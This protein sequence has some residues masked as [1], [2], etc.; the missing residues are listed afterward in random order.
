MARE[1]HERVLLGG[2]AEASHLRVVEVELGVVAAPEV[3]ATEPDAEVDQQPRPA[4]D[5][6]L[7]VRRRLRRCTSSSARP[8]SCARLAQ[9]GAEPGGRRQLLPNQPGDLVLRPDEPATLHARGAS[10]AWPGHEVGERAARSP[11]PLTVAHRSRS[12]ET[13]AG[14]PT[15]TRQRSGWLLD[16][17]PLRPGPRVAGVVEGST[18][19]RRRTVRSPSRSAGSHTTRSGVSHGSSPAAS[20][21]SKAW[22]ASASVAGVE[23][24]SSS[25]H[26]A[27]RAARARHPVVEHLALDRRST[28]RRA[29]RRVHP[30][31]SA[32]PGGSWRKMIIAILFQCK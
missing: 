18:T 9:A 20:R 4:R 8:S 17:P 11:S 27:R 26:L 29:R 5:H 24:G 7:E 28:S 22:N 30:A 2:L 31:P 19:S 16:D 10:V 12:A 25:V 14:S 32:I 6:L 15:T 23:I 3:V 13:R 21:P 1:E